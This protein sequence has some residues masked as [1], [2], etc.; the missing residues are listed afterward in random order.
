MK[1]IL[2][3]LTVALLACST[4]FAAV[5]F[6]GELVT[7][8]NL[9]FDKDGNFSGHVFGQ[10]GTDTN[11]TKLNLGIA[12]D[13][14]VWSVGIEGILVADGRV[15]GDVSIDMM[16]LFGADSDL[17]VKLGLAANDE[18]AAL[19]AYSNQSGNNYDRIRTSAAGVW[20]NL[21]VGYADLVTVTVAGSPATPAVADGGDIAGTY[22]DYAN[23]VNEALPEGTPDEEKTPTIKPTGFGANGG[24]LAV[25]ALVTPVDGVKVSV[26]YVLNGKDDDGT[27]SEGLFDAAD[28]NVGALAGLDFDL[29]VSAAYK[30]GVANKQNVIAATVY[31][32]VDAVNGYVEYAYL[33]GAKQNYLVAGANFNVVENMLLD[34]FVGAND[35]GTFGD[36]F[37]VGGDV[38]Y[39]VS[40]VTFKLGVEYAAGDA[41]S[42]D[43]TGFSIV[44]QVS[45]A[46]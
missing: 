21:S 29:G 41:F 34:V 13:N 24:D 43:E 10:D 27:G 31:G 36:T 40:G 25:S 42:Y 6:S 18:Q 4:V 2:T 1:K 38:G 12:D 37:F 44:P 22:N 8:Y 30:Y 23:K 5:N 3:I 32:G 26:G 11:T 15:S 46:F 28:V 33:S 39:T 19:R 20:A 45:V 9:N 17:S 35:L 7:G 16:K 14:G